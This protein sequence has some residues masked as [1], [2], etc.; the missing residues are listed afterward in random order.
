MAAYFIQYTYEAYNEHRYED[1]CIIDF[2]KFERVDS[3]SFY[4]KFNDKIR[5]RYSYNAKPI[6]KNVVKL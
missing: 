2:E 6:I 1:E 5:E 3:E 4:R